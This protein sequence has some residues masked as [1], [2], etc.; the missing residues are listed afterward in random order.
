M[1]ISKMFKLI[2]KFII[3]IILI[4]YKHSFANENFDQW[5]KKFQT[6]SN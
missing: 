6:L 1:I 3:F 4:I 2:L 5:L